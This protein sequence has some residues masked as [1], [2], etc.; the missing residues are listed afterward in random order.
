MDDD[1][2]EDKPEESARRP[3][4]K[5][6]SRI[7]SSTFSRLKSA[8]CFVEIDRR[9]RLGWS[10]PDLA[11]AIH[12]EF[13][14]LTD[15]SVKYLRKLLERYRAD[16]P[17]VELSMASGNSFIS[18]RA[19]QRVANGIDELSELERL[20]QMQ[21]ARIEIDLKNEENINKLLGTT[22]NEIYIAMKILKQSSDLKM[23][24]GLTKRQLGAVEVTGQM[25]AEIGDRHG[26]QNIGK[27]MA[28][29]TSRRKVL[30]IAER[31]ASLAQTAGI[32]AVNVID[33]ES[34][35]AS[36]PKAEEIIEVE[37]PSDAD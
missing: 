6:V 1:N 3:R 25:A 17:P 28:D 29:P 33:A 36:A 11:K 9:L 15:V 30:A 20:Y 7:T 22:G 19:T 32:D 10:C 12:E 31:I 13:N 27:A 23:D 35:E 26:N 37:E 24:L 5:P 4:I 34:T 16:I 8:R 2:S 18:R 21:M 14:E